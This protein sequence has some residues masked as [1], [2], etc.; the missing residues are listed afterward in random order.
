[1]RG[2]PKSDSSRNLQYRV[3]LNTC[4][5][6]MLD[7]VSDATQTPKSEI[8]R[9]ALKDYYNKIRVNEIKNSYEEDD[10]MFEPDSI[11]LKRVVNCPHCN[12]ENGID[13][14]DECEVSTDSD[15]Q[16]G[17]ENVYEFDIETT[18]VSCE[19]DFH[20]SGYISEYPLG[21]FNHE[22]INVN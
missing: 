13:F 22:E 3:R 11:S 7:Y 1:M 20:V 2:R 9:I 4:E 8:F 16:M 18:C 5:N 6:E 10:F 21:A 12:A 15:R 17:P 19:R 14:S